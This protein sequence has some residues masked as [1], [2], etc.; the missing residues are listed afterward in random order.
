MADPRR[1]PIEHIRAWLQRHAGADAAVSARLENVFFD[2]GLALEADVIVRR[3]GAFELAVVEDALPRERE[4]VIR[5][6]LRFAPEVW[7]VD[8]R[9]RSLIAAGR[10]GSTRIHRDGTITTSATRG[11]ALDLGEVFRS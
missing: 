10:D 6:W 11:H 3:A 9:G 8:L 7:V 5:R 4:D 2:D 1:R